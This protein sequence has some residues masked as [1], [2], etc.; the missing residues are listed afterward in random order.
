MLLGVRLATGIRALF[1]LAL[2]PE[3]RSAVRD[4]A[5]KCRTTEPFLRRILLDLRARGYLD[6]QKGRVGGFVLLRKPEEIKISDLAKVLEKEPMLALGRV[7]RD[8]LA[9]DP[10]CPTYP[11]WKDLEGKFLEEL[12]RLTLADVLAQAPAQVAPAEAKSRGAPGKAPKTEK[13]KAR[14]A[15]RGRGKRPG[16]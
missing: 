7:N 14:T 5:R 10:T 6:A 15:K 16:R 2:L 8:L 3:R 4:L 9:L 13:G 1:E 11:F 12:E